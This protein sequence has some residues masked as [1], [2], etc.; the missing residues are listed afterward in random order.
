MA[1]SKI[2]IEIQDDQFISV[3]FCENQVLTH[4]LNVY[5]W[6]YTQVK[7]QLRLHKLASTSAKTLGL[8]DRPTRHLRLVLSCTAYCSGY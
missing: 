1:Y 8:R 2:N 6:E 7:L 4:A 3:I 5:P